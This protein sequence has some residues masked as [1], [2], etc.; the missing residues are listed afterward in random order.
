MSITC[1]R[2]AAWVIAWDESTQSHHYLTEVDVAFQNDAI[3][4]VG[5][6]YGGPVDNEID[7]SDRLVMPGLINVHSHPSSEPLKK[8]FREEFGN[9]QMHMSPLYDRAFMLQ[10]DDAGSRTGLQYA[11]WELLRSGVTSVVDLSFPYEGWAE[12][13]ADT[14]IRAWLVPSFASAHWS[15]RDGHS[16]D[17]VWDETRGRALL[18][19]AVELAKQAES[20]R[21]GRLSAMLGPAQ[22]DTCTED[23]LLTSLGL[24]T[25]NGWRLHTHASQS[26]V[27]FQEMTRRNGTTPIQWAAKIGLLGPD[28]ILAHA[29]FID[30]HSWTR[31]PGAR[32]RELL[33]GSQTGVAHCPGVFARNGQTLE[34]LGGYLRA[35]VR[36][37]I[38]TDSFPHNMMEEMRIAAVLARVTTGDVASVTTGEVFTAAT[39]GGA[40]LLGRADL[41]RISPGA[42]A[43]I[44]MV[45]ISHPAMKPLRDPLRSLIYTAADRA[46]SEVFVDGRQV[47]ADGEVVNIDIDEVTGRLQTVREQ[48][49]ADSASHHF[50]GASAS[51]VAPLSLGF[52]P[53]S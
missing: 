40:D 25:D 39:V 38:G 7:G 41:G 9:P 37:G 15:T 51:E 53:P 10:T 23:L 52:G 31:W 16:V 43:D 42:K 34:D 33:A 13:M 5:P 36:V 26:L 18:D 32:D 46:V 14:G 12:T 27:E 11:V 19:E 48:A 22:I 28:C 3:I 49:E 4:E 50:R 44:V 30:E 17:Y 47:V 8:G 20:H 29:I 24:A 6:T 35:G 1:I 21:S 2:N 45:D